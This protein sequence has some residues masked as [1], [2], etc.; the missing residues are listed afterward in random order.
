MEIASYLKSFEDKYPAK[1]AYKHI[2]GNMSLWY[3]CSLTG[4]RYIGHFVLQY[5]GY[6]WFIK[7]VIHFTVRGC[8]ISE[9]L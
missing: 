3:N 9:Q 5:S 2:T 8:F 1:Q 6:L 7:S 4:N